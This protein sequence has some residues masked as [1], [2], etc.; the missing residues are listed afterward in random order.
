MLVQRVT[1]YVER[2]GARGGGGADEWSEQPAQGGRRGHVRLPPG[3]G[4]A[5]VRITI[6]LL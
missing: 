4:Q 5:Q 1:H 3:H 2:R 6:Y